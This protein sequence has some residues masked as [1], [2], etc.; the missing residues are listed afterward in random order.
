MNGYRDEDGGES[1]RERG[2]ANKQPI[3]T[4]EHR[5]AEEPRNGITGM[6]G[7]MRKN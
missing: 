2:Y 3:D 6:D 1:I 7:E 4:D 5:V